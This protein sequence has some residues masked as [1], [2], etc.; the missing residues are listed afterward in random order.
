[1]ITA[2]II[3]KPSLIYYHG[4]ENP[5]R[6]NTYCYCH[7]STRK[8]TDAS[9]ITQ[10]VLFVCFVGPKMSGQIQLSFPLSLALDTLSF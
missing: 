9:L 3:Q 4:T 2:V 6:L 8:A 7:D 1:M 5:P 10:M